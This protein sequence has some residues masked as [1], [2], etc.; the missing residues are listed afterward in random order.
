MRLMIAVFSLMMGVSC[1]PLL[2]QGALAQPSVAEYAQVEPGHPLH[3]PADYGAHADFR[4]EWW[5]ITGWLSD[6]NGIQRGFQ[7]TFFRVRTL[8]GE[9]NP[10]RF[11]PRQLILVHAAVADPA[12]GRLVYDE[13][14]AR[15]QPPLADSLRGGTNVWLDHW[16]LRAQHAASDSAADVYRAQVQG[17]TFAYDLMMTADQPPVLNGAAGVSRKTPEAENL[18]YYY[19]RPQLK[20]NGTLQIEGKTHQVQGHAWLDHEW[21]S[22]ILSEKYSGWNWIGINLHNGGSLMAFQM[23]DSAG[24]PV[25]CAASWRA[26]AGEPVRIVD[27]DEIRFTPLRQWISPRTGVSYPV[28]WQL[29]IAD[30]QWIISPLFDDQELDSHSAGTVYWEGAVHLKQDEKEMG[31]GYLEMTGYQ[32]RLRM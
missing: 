24:Q 5:Y 29:Q 10:S 22:R 8:L 21:S 19:S 20:V 18:S 7:V 13:K 11:S 6:E 16:H 1:I 28:E 2:N 3:F 25:W 9:D 15:A 23:R 32:Q 4:N 17:E 27:R 12:M 26:A 31:Q 30:R 14:I